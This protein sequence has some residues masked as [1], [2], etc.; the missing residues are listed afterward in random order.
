MLLKR[1]YL[2]I[3]LL[4]MLSCSKNNSDSTNTPV[5]N[6]QIIA[7]SLVLGTGASAGNYTF[8]Y[9]TDGTL[10]GSLFMGPY[11]DTISYT[12]NGKLI[13]RSVAAGINS[14][15]D[16]I[17][18]NDAGMIVQDKAQIGASVYMTNYSYD[19]NGLMATFTQ[20]QDA[21]PP[22]SA[23]YTFTNGDNT[24]I[25]S[26]TARDTLVYDI[27]KPAVMGNLD[28][29]N[30]LLNFGA[31]YIKNKHLLLEE[32]HGYG[33]FYTYTYTPEGNISS[34]KITTGNNSE[35]ISYTYNCQ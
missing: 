30:Q 10:A 7:A 29:F 28:Q 26:G 35:T 27:N 31:M 34:L 22:I 9:N 23:S 33:S 11:T 6:C 1:I 3:F 16:T 24:L 12:Y 5:V 13:Y 25:V 17:T 18:L 19:V 8:H 15:V 21:Y 32:H 2:S 14:S 20:Q 4:Y